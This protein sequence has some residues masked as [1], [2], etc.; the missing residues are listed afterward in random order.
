MSAPANTEN[1]ELQ[2]IW[3]KNRAPKFFMAPVS[4]LRVGGRSPEGHQGFH[5]KY[6]GLVEV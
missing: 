5:V 6:D 1:T 2:Q 3:A 4:L